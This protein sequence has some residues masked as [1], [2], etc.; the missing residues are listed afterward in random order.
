M[1]NT[2]SV[3]EI[4][5][6]TVKR[7][8]DGLKVKHK[9]EEW[10]G[11]IE[12]ED[13]SPTYEASHRQG[14]RLDIVIHQDAYKPNGEYV[15]DPDAWLDDLV[16]LEP[17]VDGLYAVPMIEVNANYTPNTSIQQSNETHKGES[18]R[19][20]YQQGFKEGKN[21]SNEEYLKEFAIWHT[22]KVL[23]GRSPKEEKQMLKYAKEFKNFKQQENKDE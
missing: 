6:M 19:K 20:G 21:Q 23:G 17:N 10:T 13:E 14:T 1:T 2:K 9:T 16:I 4:S 22:R 3:E 5:E 11:R 15:E 8:L 12:I 18:W 7:L